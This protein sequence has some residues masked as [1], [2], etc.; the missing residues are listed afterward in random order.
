VIEDVRDGR[1]EEDLCDPEPRDRAQGCLSVG[2]QVCL[3]DVGDDPPF[4]GALVVCIGGSRALK[5]CQAVL[6][7]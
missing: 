7:G 6:S 5:P 3:L 2:V 1:G 4:V